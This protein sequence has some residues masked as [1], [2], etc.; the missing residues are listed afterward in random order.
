MKM[1]A[2]K[3]QGFKK[4]KSDVGKRKWANVQNIIFVCP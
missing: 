3:L 2:N 4:E 1:Y